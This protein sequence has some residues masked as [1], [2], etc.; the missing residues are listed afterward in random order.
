MATKKKTDDLAMMPPPVGGRLVTMTNALIRAGNTLTLGEKRIVMFAASQ[1]DSRK[2]H[3][4]GVGAVTRISATEYA[5]T[6]GVDMNTAYDQLQ[7]AAKHLYN[8]SIQFY[9]PAYKRNGQ[10]IEPTIVTMRW[11]GRVK[12]QKKE[13]WLELA[14]WH[15]LMP[16]LTGLRRQFTTY[17]LQQASAL[18]SIYSWRMLE[19]LE[20]FS[21]TGVAQYT[22]E[23][24]CVSMGATPKQRM[25]FNNIRRRIIEPAIKELTEKDGWLIEWE[26]IKAG[27]K[28]AA[29]RFTFKRNPQGQ[30]FNS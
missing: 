25:D 29:V 28:V 23:D 22:I 10:P 8:R 15:D 12:Y 14:W 13:G 5:E 17:Q 11:V 24:F 19:L 27:R 18:R 21:S 30:L 3:Q 6:Y 2:P 16:H 1:L 4:P 26:P 9:E 7:S 20:R